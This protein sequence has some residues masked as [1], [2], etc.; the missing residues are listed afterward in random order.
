MQVV[1]HEVCSPGNVIQ[2]RCMYHGPAASSAQQL[3]ICNQQANCTKDVCFSSR[4]SG[5]WILCAAAC[6]GVAR[7]RL[8]QERKDWRKDKPFG[9]MARPESADDG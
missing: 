1:Q 3:E 9:F 5:G 2:N 8:A 6:S 7:A 4:L